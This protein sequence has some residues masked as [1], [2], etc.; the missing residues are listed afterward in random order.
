MDNPGSVWKKKVGDDETEYRDA[1]S[2]EKIFGGLDYLISGSNSHG[3][4]S[5]NL[6][7]IN[8]DLGI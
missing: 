7:N 4:Q 6:H 8:T 2:L 1:I 5:I 3:V